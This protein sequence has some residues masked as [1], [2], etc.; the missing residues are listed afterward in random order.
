ME[1]IVEPDNALTGRHPDALSLAN[2]LETF[3]RE[4]T[5]LVWYGCVS[6]SEDVG[7]YVE[8]TLEPPLYR[9]KHRVVVLNGGKHRVVVLNGGKHWFDGAIVPESCPPTLRGP[10]QVKE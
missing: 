2:N 7:W 1:P 6:R 3:L 5:G 4:A 9:R 10:M 8:A